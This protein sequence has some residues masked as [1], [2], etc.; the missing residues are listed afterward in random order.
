M[1]TMNQVTNPEAADSAWKWLYKV[2]GVAALIM[3]ALIPIQSF[4]FIAWPPPSTVI[5]YFTLFQNN[6]LLGLLDLDLLLIVDNVLLILIYLA[7]YTVLRR[8]NESFMAIALIFGLVGAVLHFASR[9]ATFTML[10]LSD[11]YAAATT[12]AQRAMLL[13]AGQAM[14]TIYNGTAFDMSY[15]LSGVVLLIISVVMLRSNIFSKGTAYVGILMGVLML[16]PPTVGTI[17]L[18]LSLISLV[19]TLI[20]LILIARKLF[21]LG[22]GTSKEKA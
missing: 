14:L 10:S 13:A 7:L 19:P 5:D 9:E 8:A 3:A 18:L 2:G 22:Q 15:V 12:D 6:K 16:V 4:I 11:Q 20:W 21:Q 17:G 1:K